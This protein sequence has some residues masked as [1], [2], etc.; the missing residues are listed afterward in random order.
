LPNEI[1]FGRVFFF[2]QHLIFCLLEGRRTDNLLQWW[3]CCGNGRK[4]LCC[5]RE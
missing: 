5:Y 2:P 1:E 3:R 4:K